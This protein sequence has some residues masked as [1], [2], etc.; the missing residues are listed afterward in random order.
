MWRSCCTAADAQYVVQESALI[1]KGRG[2][3]L[4]YMVPCRPT[5]ASPTDPKHFALLFTKAR[6]RRGWTLIRLSTE[7]EVSCD[8]AMR[9]CTHGRC[10]STT[11]LQLAHALGIQLI[12]DTREAARG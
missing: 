10:S 6:L 12:P 7:A 3:S 5:P 1:C 9:A 2:A 11:T 4:T 8:T